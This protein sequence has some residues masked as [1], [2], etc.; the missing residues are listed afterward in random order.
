MTRLDV[1][2]VEAH[3]DVRW[4]DLHQL[5]ERIL[6]P[7]A[8]RNRPADR[9]LVARQLLAAVDAR[10]V[11]TGAGLID[12]RVADVEILELARHEFGHERLGLA[13]GRAVTDGD[14]GA[15][16]GAG[17]FH[18]LLRRRRPLLILADNVQDGV[19]ER[20]AALVDYHRLAAALEAGVEGQHPPARHGRLEQQI[21][22]VPCEHLHGV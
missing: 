14:H 8:D 16:V 17:E 18:D 13:T 3:A 6:Q 9:G 12:D 7:A 5:R 11:D 4:L 10:R 22:Q 21:S 20:R 19:S 1:V 15:A 2:L